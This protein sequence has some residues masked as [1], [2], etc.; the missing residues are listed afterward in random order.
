MHKHF[1]QMWHYSQKLQLGPTI[2]QTGV[3][4]NGIYSHRSIITTRSQDNTHS[5]HWRKEV[6]CSFSKLFLSLLP[7]WLE[8]F[9]PIVFMLLPSPSRHEDVLAVPVE[10]MFSP[11]NFS[12]VL[13]TAVTGRWG[14][15]NVTAGAWAS[16]EEDSDIWKPVSSRATF[17]WP[18]EKTGERK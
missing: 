9:T 12:G 18:E 5:T 3:S 8:D 4:C 15:C 2:F 1:L 17:A 11:E 14:I 13:V 10:E 7:G 6:G 16:G